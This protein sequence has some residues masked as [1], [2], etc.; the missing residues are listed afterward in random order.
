VAAANADFDSPKARKA[1][2]GTT[3]ISTDAKV[4]RNFLTELA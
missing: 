3:S 2:N 1:L 4:P